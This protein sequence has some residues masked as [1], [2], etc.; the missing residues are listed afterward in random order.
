MERRWLSVD[1][2]ATHLGISRDTVYKWMERKAMPARK[3][4]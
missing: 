2:A 4:G 1:E 3:V